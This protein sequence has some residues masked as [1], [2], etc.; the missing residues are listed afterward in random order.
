MSIR[1][2]HA[3]RRGK[4]PWKYYSSTEEILARR[5]RV[6][7]MTDWN[8]E[9]NKATENV[10]ESTTAVIRKDGTKSKPFCIYSKKGKKLGCFKTRKGAEDRLAEIEMFK[11]M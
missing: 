11:H 4:K 1:L 7:R 10:L 9:L 2:T 3:E 5:Q 6:C 8:E